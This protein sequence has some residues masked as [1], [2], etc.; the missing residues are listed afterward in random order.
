MEFSVG[1]IVTNEKVGDHYFYTGSM[2]PSEENEKKKGTIFWLIELTVPDSH[3]PQLIIKQIK[4]YYQQKEDGI[5]GFEQALKKVNASLALQIQNK[6]TTWVTHL[7]AILGLRQDETVHLAPTGD[8]AAYLFR[9]NKISNILDVEESPPPHQ[10]FISVI[11]GEVEAGDKMFLATSEFT[12]YMTI[13]TLADFLR[14]PSEKAIANIAQY[15]RE[16][17]I[18]N[19]NSLALDFSKSEMT[20]DSVY[21]DQRPET[22]PEK[23][24]KILT[25]IKDITFA[26]IN[27]AAQTIGKAEYKILINYLAKKTEQR[28][29]KKEEAKPKLAG[30]IRI[31]AGNR[32]SKLK[33]IIL[34]EKRV[35]FLKKNQR[36]IF[37]SL[38]ILLLLIFGATLYFRNRSNGTNS[39]D[40]LANFNQAKTLIDQAISEETTNPENAYNLLL[41]AK[42]L[43]DPA[44]NYTPTSSEAMA[45]DQKI[46]DEINKITNTTVISDATENIG[47][48]ATQNNASTNRIFDTTN[49]IVSF[50]KSGNQFLNLDPS[51]KKI[52]ELFTLSSGNTSDAVLFN[53]GE[54][55]LIKNNQN[56]FFIYSF[57]DKK[58]SDAQKSG[59][60]NW[61]NGKL[62]SYIDKI[63]IL[64]GNELDRFNYSGGSF[65]DGGIAAKSESQVQSCAIDGS[66][67]FLTTNAEIEQYTSG[68][69]DNLTLNKPFFLKNLTD[70]NLLYT[71][72]NVSYLFIYQKS[73]NRI[74]LFDKT[75]DFQKQIVIP[76][77]WGEINDIIAD[78]SGNLYLLANNKIYKISY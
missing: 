12:S 61:P 39:Q 76:D 23:T 43:N 56:Q 10:T 25:K 50:N 8:V 54:D 53:S 55:M 3:V 13:E 21:L 47:D 36:I 5:W 17:N 15:F 67:Y 35:S 28:E 78:V 77:T 22:T 18:R 72:A 46:N 66:V 31:E 52:S 75:G 24:F 1:K 45:L 62:F 34:D 41:Q 6:N 69:K 42:G 59:N 51:N 63:Y 20:V 4:K 38:A 14:E 29:A 73:Q 44:K 68:N 7:N 64:N 49:A 60:F 11:S 16:K 2:T 30:S 57:T 27:A 70:A 32:V 58:V 9:E 19:I 71:D 48:F 74:V 65:A 26:G 37:I 33:N 40:V